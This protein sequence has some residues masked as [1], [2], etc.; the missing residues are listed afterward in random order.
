MTHMPKNPYCQ[1][2]Q[3]AKVQHVP[4]KRKRGPDVLAQEPKVFGEQLT[5]DHIIL[6]QAT[7][8]GMKGEST[9]LVVSDRATGWLDAF[10]LPNKS[11]EE[12]YGALNKVVSRGGNVHS[13]HTDDAPELI[14][15]IRDLGWQHSTATPGRPQTNGVAERAVKSVIEGVRTV[16]DMAGTGHRWWPLAM[17]H[18]VFSNNII[19]RNG[20]SPW[21]KR[22]QKGAFN[23]L[24]VPFG[25]LVDFQPSPVQGKVTLKFGC[26]TIPGL[27]AGYY[28]L[29]GGQWRGDYLVV[30]LSDAV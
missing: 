19:D 6:G 30:P 22:H 5:A 24:I 8:Y 3:R 25:S 2:C 18:F 15:A 1:A 16:M 23:G 17:G 29:P 27:F 26:K 12:A 9:A 11:S 14:K 28:V 4:A 10:P 13:I 20:D 21:Q 7:E